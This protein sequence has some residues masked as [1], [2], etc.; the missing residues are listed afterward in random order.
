MKST[1]ITIIILSRKQNTKML[2][3]VKIQE[4][5]R[6]IFKIHKQAEKSILLSNLN[7]NYDCQDR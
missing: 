3:E 5:F 1:H 4:H 2:K 6:A 7:L